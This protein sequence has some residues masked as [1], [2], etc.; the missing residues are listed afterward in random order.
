MPLTSG[1]R[2]GPYEIVAPL[3]AGGMGE[4]YSARDTRLKREVAIKVLPD[5]FATDPERLARFQSEAELLATLNHPNI[6]AVYGIEHEGDTRAIVME[7]VGGETLAERLGRSDLR[8]AQVTPSLSRGDDRAL[9]PSVASASGREQSLD[10]SERIAAIPIDEALPIARQIAVALEAAHDRGVVHRD[11][12]PANIKVT[13]EGVVKVLDFGLAKL[14]EAE[15]FSSLTMSPTL[16]IQATHAGVILGTAAYMSPEQA[17]GKPIDRRADIWSFGC[18][19]YEMLT[20]RQ[21][22][23]AEGDTVSD[24]IAAILKADVDWSAMPAETPAHI[25]TLLR[26]CLQ[27]DAQ[28]RL[29]HIGL[30]R[31]DIDEGG[32]EVPVPVVA[33]VSTQARGRAWLPWTIAALMLIVSGALAALLILRREPADVGSAR[34]EV[35][36]PD[37]WTFG[38]NDP[39][40]GTGTPAPH[41][42]VSPDGRRIAY[43]TYATGNPQLWVRRLDALSGQPLPG[44]DEASFPFWSPDGRFVAFFAA[45]KL[46]K[47]DASGGPPLT[48]CDAPLGEGGTWSHD[49]VIVFAPDTVGPLA[50]VSAAGGVAAPVTML[51]GSAGETSHRWPQFLPDRRHFLYLGATAAGADLYVGSLDSQERTLVM[52]G[53]LRAAY[54]AGYLLFVREGGLMAQPFDATSH[55]LSGEPTPVGEDIAFNTVNHRTGFSASDGVL[56]YRT[57]GA[58][59]LSVRLSKFD[60]TG[61]RV[62]TLDAKGAYRSLRLSPAGTALAVRNDDTNSTGDWWI[63]D[64]TRGAV[65]TRLTV[66]GRPTGTAFWSPDGS[67]LVF[68][69]GT[70]TNW[71]QKAVAG[72]GEAELLLQTEQRKSGG[73]WSPD[74]QF[75]VYEEYSPTSDM[76]LWVLPMSKD[77]KPRVFLQTKFVEARARFSP[78]GQWLAYVSNEGGGVSDVYVRSFPAGDRKWRVS[79]GGGD[80]PV[81]RR[82]G[83]ELFYLANLN[84]MT[85]VDIRADKS[86]EAG[87]PHRLFEMSIPY[88]FDVMPDGQQFVIGQAESALA[89]P[90]LTILVNWLALL[91]K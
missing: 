2:L 61:R 11:L 20:G 3:G 58:S 71:Y 54:A 87:A 79:V 34:F 62:E 45:G 15:P 75:I 64:L 36:A 90:T 66:G 4:V 16:S 17:R 70:P 74:G 35:A 68:G 56:A 53:A 30:A 32:G 73:D 29:P 33:A 80:F 19:L 83:K 10:R 82:D 78:D 22:F 9:P 5:A 44:T 8:Q 49:G 81:W 13:P 18:V 31:M 41:V 12:K 55:R 21:A 43:V 67:R 39:S 1:T 72:G 24:A 86:F 7:L 37:G 6:A 50:R 28:K 60:R 77:A 14:S 69:F 27:K 47:I 40:R 38:Q 76:D 59:N 91:K 48:I 65:P 26:R 51:D 52:K 25:R 85:A 46:K 88:G 23:A 42:A 89:N 84:K 63:L 57:G